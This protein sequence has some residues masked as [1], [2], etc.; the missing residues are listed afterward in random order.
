MAKKIEVDIDDLYTVRWGIN[1]GTPSSL[2]EALR[3]VNGLLNTPSPSQPST[4]APSPSTPPKDDGKSVKVA[5]VVGHNSSAQGANA[6]SP[7]N[8]SEYIFNNEVADYLVANPPK[9]VVFK[10]FLRKPGLS[11]SKEIDTVYAEVN[12]WNPE[13][14]LELHFNAGGGHYTTMVYAKVSTKGKTFA[15]IIQD[16]ISSTYG[17]TKGSMIAADKNS[18]RGGRSLYAAKAPIVL[19]EPFFGDSSS[20]CESIGKLGAAGLAEA[21][22]RAVSKAISK[23][24]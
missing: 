24:L 19:T 18:T 16:E 6:K 4:P 14:A 13:L 17:F 20:N 1:T 12:A 7:I 21:Y 5:I 3:V 15:E 11:Y 2:E 9:G 10:K 22:K 23:L 8:K